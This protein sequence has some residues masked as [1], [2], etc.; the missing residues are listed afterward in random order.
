MGSGA[1]VV[2]LLGLMAKQSSRAEVEGISSDKSAD[3]IAAAASAFRTTSHATAIYTAINALVDASLGQDVYQLKRAILLAHCLKKRGLGA[4][5]DALVRRIA[6]TVLRSSERSSRRSPAGLK[7]RLESRYDDSTI[8][9][10][11]SM[12]FLWE[13]D[14]GAQGFFKEEMTTFLAHS[15]LLEP[16][17]LCTLMCKVA[18]RFAVKDGVEDAGKN[19]DGNE[20][21]SD[22]ENEEE[23]P[24]KALTESEAESLRRDLERLGH[25][26]IENTFNRA[27]DAAPSK[28]HSTV[29]QLLQLLLKFDSLALLSAFGAKVDG[30]PAPEGGKDKDGVQHP[31]LYLLTAALLEAH[32]T[33]ETADDDDATD[34]PFSA[35]A[36]PLLARLCSGRIVQIGEDG[37]KL[38]A[39]PPVFTWCMPD[40]DAKDYDEDMPEITAF[41]RS[42]EQTLE[43]KDQWHSWM[44]YDTDNGSSC[45]VRKTM[46]YSAK[47]TSEDPDSDG[48]E[49]KGVVQKTRK[50]HER[51]VERHAEQQTELRS[52]MQMLSRFQT[53]CP[54]AAETQ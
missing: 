36:H 28:T 6:A 39:P 51:Q 44:D 13:A 41:L 52:V 48:P 15:S 37:I 31:M 14:S 1:M 53:G 12:I 32:A 50:Y 29:T 2:R 5:A 49:Y 54:N 22:A 18:K 43:T 9:K 25:R 10:F 38:G 34:L 35:Q 3:T 20:S 26:C 27:T 16:Q 8:V 19:D 11:G 17:A 7:S 42:D 45:N 21:D 23:Q 4:K 33:R 47:Y 40:A 46:T 30:M 24:I